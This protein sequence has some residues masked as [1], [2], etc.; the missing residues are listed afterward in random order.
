MGKVLTIGMATFDDY[1]G[2]Y[3]SV[4]ALRLYHPEVINDIEIIVVDN[5]P[6]GPISAALKDLEHWVAG[7][8]Y[9]PFDRLCG[10]AVRDVIFRESNAE[11]VL[12]MDSHVMF[13]P[14]ALGKLLSYFHAHPNSPDLLQ[15]PL[16]YD[17][18]RNLST[19]MDRIWSAGMY[20]VWATDDRAN[21]P[22][23]PPFEIEMQGLGVF[24]CRKSAWPG[25]N[26]RLKGFGGEEGYIQEKFRRAGGRTLCLPFLRWIHRFNRPAG[27][28]YQNTWE[29]R[30]RNYLIIADELGIDPSPALEHFRGYLGWHV[31]ERIVAAVRAELNNPF[32]FFDAIYCLNLAEESA[33]W[34]EVCARFDRLG[35]LHRVRRFEALRTQP[36]HHVGC[37]LSHR[38]VVEEAKRQGLANVLVFEDDVLFTSDAISSL[39]TALEELRGRDWR[40]LYLGA[41]R[42][43]QE[44]PLLQGATRL[45]EAG[46]VTCTHAVAFHHSVFD[47]ILTEV[48]ASFAG[49]E[50]WLRVHHGIDQYFAFHISQGKYLV[51]PVVA[52]QAN[53]LPLESE[54]VRERLLA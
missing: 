37:A 18:L 33:R 47:R 4:M 53:I 29:D 27:V 15:G 35:I 24:A 19:H 7:Y 36:N 12:C 21:D 22:A 16:I 10:T 2:V 46:A 48:P 30:L 41:C 11:F 50:E 49:M 13:V 42:W 34:K 32:H 51:S 20:G 31:A 14:G 25:F 26:P 43:R 3:F 5:H 8:R 54:E 17:D 52:T 40:M 9:I 44:F 38:A 28:P 23:A 45:A 6:G 39:M 1:D